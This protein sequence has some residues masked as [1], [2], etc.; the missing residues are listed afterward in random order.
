MRRH[1][2]SIMLYGYGNPG[3]QDDGLGIRFVEEMEQWIQENELDFITTDS[4]YQL[5]IEDSINICS[6]DTVFFI[7]AT[8]EGIE[9]YLITKIKPSKDASFT[10]H[11]VSPEFLLDMCQSLF[12]KA[13]DA[14]LIHIKGYEWEFKEGL[15]IKAENNLRIAINYMKD[16]LANCME[17]RLTH[18]DAQKS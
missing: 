13:L 12:K 16:V 4:N 2:Q 14:Y 7:D 17:E 9:D 1:P 10:T 11:S 8:K 3:R 6:C 18:A 5:N 15:T